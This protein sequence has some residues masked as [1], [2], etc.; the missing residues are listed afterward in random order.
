MFDLVRSLT[1][2]SGLRFRTAA[3]LNPWCATGP[4]PGANTPGPGVLRRREISDP[5]M[6]RSQP[7]LPMQP[8]IPE[9]RT[10]DYLRA[11]GPCRPVDTGRAA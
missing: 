6:G 1:R 7:V 11:A 9:R 8:G 2:G 10:H 5:D 4:V 3:Q